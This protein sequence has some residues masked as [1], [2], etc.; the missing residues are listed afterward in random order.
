MPNAKREMTLSL[1]IGVRKLKESGSTFDHLNGKTD[2][3]LNSLS[4]LTL[5]TLNSRI[6]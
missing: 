1:V 5:I 6:T 2:L 3:K 4:F